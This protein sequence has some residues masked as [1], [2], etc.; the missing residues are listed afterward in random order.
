MARNSTAVWS[1]TWQPLRVVLAATLWL[2]LGSQSAR[3]EGSFEELG[4]I[5]GAYYAVVEHGGQVYV[6]QGNQLVV[7]DEEGLRSGRVLGRVRTSAPLLLGL[8]A[9]DGDGLVF[10][11][12]ATSGLLVLDVREASAPREVAA[13]SGLGTSASVA[14][15]GTTVYVAD[16]TGWLH[17]V[18]VADPARPRELGRTAVPGRA[19]RLAV[20][21]GLLWLVAHD[22]AVVAVDV[23]V[24][25]APR[26]SASFS[27]RA[28]DV[29]ARGSH[30]FVATYD[31]LAVID[32]G[33]WR[34]P[35]YVARAG[36]SQLSGLALAG[37]VAW[38]FVGPNNQSLL[39]AWDVTNPAQP[40]ELGY[41]W[42]VP[43]P[44]SYSYSPVARLSVVG[45]R[46]ALTTGDPGLWVIQA[47]DPLHPALDGL[48]T[49]M[50][51]GRDL[52][53]AGHLAAVSGAEGGQTTL[54]DV[55]DDTLPQ[56]VGAIGA[57]GAGPHRT[58]SL[59]DWLYVTTMNGLATIRQSGSTLGPQ[60]WFNT[61]SEGRDVAVLDDKHLVLAA[62]LWN[63]SS[64][65]GALVVL[66]LADPA[67]PKEISR[68][69]LAG[70]P[71]RLVLDGHR[72]HVSLAQSGLATVDLSDP[73]HPVLTDQLSLH[74]SDAVGIARAPDGRL[75]VGTRGYREYEAT[76]YFLR[77]PALWA[78]GATDTVRGCVAG[79][80][81]LEPI[82]ADIDGFTGGGGVAY[83]SG[84]VFLAAGRAGLRAIDVSDPE[85]PVDVG[86]WRPAAPVTDVVLRNGQLLVLTAPWHLPGT[87]LQPAGGLHVLRWVEPPPSPTPV[88]AR[89]L[90]LR[91]ALPFNLFFPRL[92]L[93]RCR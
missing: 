13:L 28:F 57:S 79:S 8:A 60:G 69:Q 41:V 16:E 88:P 9:G 38:G 39:R 42:H 37:N 68:F 84:H 49:S 65:I 20:A 11:A 67:W 10:A 89:S 35:R 23:T 82:A 64:R 12:A 21:G 62:S 63:G 14:A 52:T 53:L 66:N 47:R 92:T 70:E 46:L 80:L 19:T 87:S 93:E 4:S 29:V 36:S 71:R 76:G 30:V 44:P 6:A 59:G 51:G 32:A 18:S 7:T 85:Q 22:A 77:G 78:L 31:G 56:V 58:A 50:S 3:A 43:S 54:L 17:V 48:V 45:S 74:D 72:A 26:L 40:R 33:D 83:Q 34:Q 25:E 24:P 81:R 55:S 27:L 86:G 1:R 15:A 2:V 73:S 5:G 91:Q 61:W 75:F 90:T